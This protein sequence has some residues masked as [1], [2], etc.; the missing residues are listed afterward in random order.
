MPDLMVAKIRRE[1]IRFPVRKDQRADGV[2]ESSRDQQGDGSHAELTINR[3]DQ[4]NNDPAHQQKTDT[5]HQD[6]NFG[7]EDGFNRDKENRQTP[8]DAEQTPACAAAK[9]R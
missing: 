4:K 2:E 7:K 9:D 6:G 5:R 1:W 8:N 3:P